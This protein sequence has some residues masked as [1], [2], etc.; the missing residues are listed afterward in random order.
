MKRTY[1]FLYIFLALAVLTACAGPLSPTG[2]PGGGSSQ[3]ITVAISNK[4]RINN[5]VSTPNDQTQLVSGNTAFAF[6][7]YQQLLSGNTGNLFYSPYSISVALSM[8]RAGA[9][10]GTLS[11]MDQAMHYTLSGDALYQAF[12]ALQLALAAE[13]KNEGNPSENDFTLNV[14]NAAWGQNGYKFLQAYLDTLAEN[15]SAGMRLVDFQSDPEKARQAINDWVAQ[16]TAQK[17]KDLIPQGSITPLSRLVLTNAIYFNSPWLSPFNESATKDGTFTNL[18]DKQSTVPMMNTQ[19]TFGYAQGD[20]YQVVELPYSGDKLSMLVLV[21][22]SGQFGRIE[23]SLSQDLVASIRQNLQSSSVQLSMPKF[24][25]ESDVALSDILK[26][27]GMADAFDPNKADLSGMD[28]TRSL[29]ISDV[30]HK[31]YVSVDEKGTEAAAATAVVIGTLSMPSQVVTL[32]IDRPFIFLIQ[33]NQSGSIL[34]VGRVTA[35]G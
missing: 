19:H 15:Y 5:P 6:D 26:K 31:A 9:K 24:K 20:G 10:G 32:T 8:A 4:S 3:P 29:F 1:P 34:F 2:T 18:D 33:D 12:N 13:Q 11:Q 7:L 35:L 27:M 14:V 21:P 25:V 30:L 28:G 22:D 17:I 23:K 16:Q